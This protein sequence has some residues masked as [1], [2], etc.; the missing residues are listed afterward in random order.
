MVCINPHWA[1]LKY[2]KLSKLNI[3][4]GHIT[5]KGTPYLKFKDCNHDFPVKC[6]KCIGC[7]LDHAAE[8]ACRI[9]MEAQEH[10][11]NCF[12]TL[13][14]NQENLPIA[15]T[16]FPTLKKTDVQLFLKKLR[17]YY[18]NA[19]IR[20]VVAGEYG[21]KTL[22]PH[23]H[24]A[25]HGWK[26]NDLKEYKKNEQGDMTYKSKNLEKIWGKGFVV[27]GQLSQ[28]SASYIA[29]YVTK[30]IHQ[31]EHDR[32]G[33]EKEYIIYSKKPAI[34]LTNW[35]KNKE[36][37][38]KNGGIYI[39]IKDKVRLFPIPT[40][41]QRKRQEAVY[42]DYKISKFYTENGKYSTKEKIMLESQADFLADCILEERYYTDKINNIKKAKQ[43]LI[44][45]QEQTDLK[46]NDYLKII[47]EKLERN[48][49]LLKRTQI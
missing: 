36:K 33:T 3:K 42:Q 46:Y 32:A 34:G 23:Y 19:N 7:K 13:T 11:E 35:N 14:Y 30:K 21:P 43:R 4:T 16:G 47:K 25:V 31:K 18:P 29:R 48:E 12:V 38:I 1:E 28:Q 22:R 20:Y 5:L 37:Y 40:L 8:V 10:N 17:Y 24:L 41:F 15:K 9:W 39:K 27:I 49:K 45:I 26:P 44:E 6:G 2:R